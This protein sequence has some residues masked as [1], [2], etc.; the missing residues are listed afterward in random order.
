VPSWDSIRGP[1][2]ERSAERKRITAEWSAI[3]LA[4]T[5]TA[6]NYPAGTQFVFYGN[7][8]NGMA[9]GTIQATTSGPFTFIAVEASGPPSM[10]VKNYPPAVPSLKA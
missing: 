8:S 1:E 9:I 5:S 4:G 6:L 3:P 10:S 2:P 7:F